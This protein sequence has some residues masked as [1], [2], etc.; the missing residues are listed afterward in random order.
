MVLPLLAQIAIAILLGV[1]GAVSWRLFPIIV[2]RRF[3]SPL[4]KLRGPPSSSWL[5][6]HLKDK[7][8]SDDDL[9]NDRWV[10]EYG[11]VCIIR[12][13]FNMAVLLATDTRAINHV[14]THSAHYHKPAQ[15]QRDLSRLLGE[16]VLI[17]EGEQHR[18]QRRIMNPAFGPAQI[19][20]LTEIFVEKANQLRDVWAA[21]LDAKGEP[22][23]INVIRGLSKMTLDVI[24]LAGE[25]E[26][27]PESDRSL[28]AE[29][30]LAGFNYEFNAL[31]PRGEQN[32]LAKA[33]E[34]VFSFPAKIPVLM[35]LRN[36]FPV[37]EIIK[38]KRL[39][40]IEYARRTMHRIGSQLM[41]QKKAEILRE[42]SGE[43]SGGVGKNSVQGRD[44][45]TLLIKANT[46]TDIPDSQRLSDEDVLAQVPTFLVAGHETTSTATS[47]CL[48]ALS[49]AP[50]VQ[51][52][53]RDELLTVDTETPTMDELM[54]LPYLDMVL[55]ESLRLYPAVPE[56]GRI[57]KR[58]D[59]IPLDK[60]FTDKNGNVQDHVRIAK[61]D[62]ILIPIKTVNRLESLWGADAH[63]FRPERWE[64]PPA[65]V[66][67]IPGV[68]GHVLSFLGGPRACIGYR[69]SIVE[70]VRPHPVPLSLS[71][72]PADRRIAPTHRMKALLFALVRAFEFAPAVDPRE[73]KKGPGH[74]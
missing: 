13:F 34:E 25:S 36:L 59:I 50:D 47:W 53:L 62:I 68:W 69:F 52:K 39:R 54:A 66:S 10:K 46:A 37:F 49:Q 27:L 7:H 45:L 58:D 12:E 19:R 55:R 41:A 1:L 38:D 71:L 18:Q 6:G 42:S 17:T 30:T 5:F 28:R 14:L 72:S 65:A 56:T 29:E 60:P 26:S 70:Y 11:P 64:N 23:R 67:T 61:G 8:L 63:E 74:R 4:L 40:D 44:L 20:G 32:E 9:L 35:I 3:T 51:R 2:P 16:G 73:I 24:G 31:N 15:A 21:E 57:A 43:K 22:T 48:Y 33:F